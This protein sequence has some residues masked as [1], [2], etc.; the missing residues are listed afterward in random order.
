MAAFDRLPAEIKKVVEA[1]IDKMSKEELARWVKAHLR[2]NDIIR[3]V[4]E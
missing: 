1:K 2:P 3:L 4:T